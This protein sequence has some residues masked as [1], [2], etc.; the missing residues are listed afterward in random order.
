MFEAV[1]FT[2]AD[3][4]F[5]SGANIRE[6]AQLTPRSCASSFPSLV[7]DCFKPLRR[8]N[9]SRLQRSTATAWVARWI[10]RLPAT[11]AWL[12]S[13]PCSRTRARGL[14]IITGWGGT[15]RLPRM[16]GRTRALEFFV[17]A[18]RYSSAAALEMGLVS[19]GERS[20]D[21]LRNCVRVKVSVTSESTL[22][23]V[24]HS[25][26]LKKLRQFPS[27]NLLLAAR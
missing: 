5:A 7:N 16:I 24:L 19:Q 9:S 14:G 27:D 18:K 12:R 3:D 6:L 4:V 1:I 25:L 15:Q 11:S 8:R 21:R 17:T 26:L 23:S 22:T 2:G 20:S 13:Q 10:L